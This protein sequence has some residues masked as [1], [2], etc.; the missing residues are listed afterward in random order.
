VGVKRSYPTALKWLNQ[1]VTQNNADA[2]FFF[3]LMYEHG[4]GIEQDI[5]KSLELFDRAAA[6]G[7]RYAQMEAKGMR[8]Q[9]EANRIGALMHQNSG[10][11]D[12]ACET[13]GGK[14]APGEC[15]RVAR[16][17]IRGPRRRTKAISEQ[18]VKN[19]GPFHHCDADQHSTIAFEK[20]EKLQPPPDQYKFERDGASL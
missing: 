2:M 19:S 15:M 7:Q 12:I 14:P 10:T 5:P 18:E 4:R 11:E 9:G 20:F 3:G 8:L 1:A 17:L 13:A 6:L 16:T